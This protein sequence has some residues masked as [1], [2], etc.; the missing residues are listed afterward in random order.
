MGPRSTFTSKGKIIHLSPTLHLPTR[1]S[2]GLHNFASTQSKLCDGATY[3]TNMPLFCG[4]MDKPLHTLLKAWLCLHL[5]KKVPRP[6]HMSPSLAIPTTGKSF[7]VLLHRP[8]CHLHHHL[9]GKLGRKPPSWSS[10]YTSLL[11]LCV[12][13]QSSLASLIPNYPA[14]SPTWSLSPLAVHRQLHSDYQQIINKKHISPSSLI[15]IP[16]PPS[17]GHKT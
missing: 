17:I 3:H 5:P 9:F 13:C 4:Q 11:C 10:P 12:C 15:S 1:C 6:W 8:P 7:L 14:L 16:W 2:W